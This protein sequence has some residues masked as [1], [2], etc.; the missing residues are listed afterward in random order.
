M[1]IQTSILF[2]LLS[3]CTSAQTI[4]TPTGSQKKWH[5][6][7][8]GAIFHY[9]IHVFDGERY[10]QTSNRSIQCVLQR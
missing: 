9:D 6:A 2:M 1:K 4:V 3:V 10:V 5:E 7:E 8:M